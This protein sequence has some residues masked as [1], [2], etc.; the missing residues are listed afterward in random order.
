MNNKEVENRIKN[1]EEAVATLA[2]KTH[3]RESSAE[4][5]ISI[6]KMDVATACQESSVS[7]LWNETQTYKVGDYV[8]HKNYLFRCL[9]ANYGVEP[10]DARYWLE[11]SLVRELNFINERK[12][13]K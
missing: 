8:L 9:I 6:I 4:N 7:D 13:D 12:V 10:G 11:T 3:S 1:L 2:Q 5:S